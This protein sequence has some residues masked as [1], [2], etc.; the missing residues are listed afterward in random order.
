MIQI[1]DKLISFDVF[2]QHFCCDLPQ[3]LG[4]C[5]VH[6]LSGAPLEDE[7]VEI[8]KNELLAID[9]Y[10]KPEGREAIKD[11]GVAVRDFEGDMVT[12]L[13]DGEECAFCI[14]EDGITMCAIER[15]WI[16]GKVG[17]RKPISCHLYP[18]R[19]K[20]YSTFTAINYDRWSVCNPARV[21]G[22]KQGVPVY[23]FLR[24]ALIRAYGEAFY[25]EME[26]SAKLLEQQRIQYQKGG[27]G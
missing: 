27:G 2:E 25:A 24:E 19:V 22:K 7:E 23:K 8:L 10:L 14:E 5:C 1:D 9:P 26:E 3:C 17:F 12:P 6:G 4:A 21:L 11:Q 13:I 18:I 20:K 16:D 15:A